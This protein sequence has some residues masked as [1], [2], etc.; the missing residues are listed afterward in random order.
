MEHIT[1][2]DRWSGYCRHCFPYIDLFF[3][4]A[5]AKLYY[6]F[7]HPSAEKLY[8]LLENL[9][10]HKTSQNTLDMLEGLKHW[11]DS[12][13]Q[14][15][16]APVNFCVSLGTES[17]LFNNE[18][19]MDVMYIGHAPTA[20]VADAATKFGAAH[21]LPD[22]NT[23]TVWAAFVERWA[24]VYTGLPNRI[25]I[26]RGSWIEENVYAVAKHGH[27]DVARSSIEAHSSLQIGERYHQ[28]WRNTFRQAKL[29]MASHIPNRA[30][31][32]MFRISMKDTLGPKAFVP[33]ALFFG[34]FHLQRSLKNHAIPS[35]PTRRE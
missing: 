19:H 5:V 20:H 11:C 17:F 16:T 12:C 6:K 24:S 28:S 7:I 27:F 26:D 29:S 22:I 3:S 23:T 15:Q 1:Y 34:I 9:C 33:P 18:V 2:S 32:A 21:F 4:S 13:Q 8:K 31:I 30:V 14:N 35:P 10:L 25:R